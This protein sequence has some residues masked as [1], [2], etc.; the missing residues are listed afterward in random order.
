MSASSRA[1]RWWTARSSVV[2]AARRRRR[3]SSRRHSRC[4]RSWRRRRPVAASPTPPYR[5]ETERLVL[6][7]WDPADSDALDEA[8]AE[9]L[10]ELRPW[11]P[12][13]ADPTVEPTHEV[14]RRFRAAFDLGEEH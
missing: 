8:V 6:R 9:S 10:D 5:I 1:P 13:A 14:L 12:W 2:A 4:S 3:R 11:M 7:C